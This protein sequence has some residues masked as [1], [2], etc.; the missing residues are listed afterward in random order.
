MT[1]NWVK[2]LVLTNLIYVPSS[3][4]IGIYQLTHIFDVLHCQDSHRYAWAG[5]A[6]VPRGLKAPTLPKDHDIKRIRYPYK[7]E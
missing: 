4:S 5:H 2:T 3:S 7:V 6:Q 1:E